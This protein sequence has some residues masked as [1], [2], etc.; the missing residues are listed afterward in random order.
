MPKEALPQNQFYLAKERPIDL[1]QAPKAHGYDINQFTLG[2]LHAN[3]VKLIYSLVENGVIDELSDQDYQTFLQIYQSPAPLSLENFNAF[4]DFI[5]NQLTIKDNQIL[6]R[7]IGDILADRGRN[8][9]FILKILQK[10][11]ANGVEVRI[12]LSNHDLEFLKGIGL[13][14]PIRKDARSSDIEFMDEIDALED[15]IEKGMFVDQD[16]IDDA[17]EQIQALYEKM[18]GGATFYEINAQGNSYIELSDLIDNE[19]LAYEEV[20]TLVREVYVPM[21]QMIDYSQDNTKTTIYT[22]AHNGIDDIFPLATSL[23]LT[24]HPQTLDNLEVIIDEINHFI[25]QILMGNDNNAFEA[26]FESDNLA[27][28]FL[29]QRQDA[30]IIDSKDVRAAYSDRLNFVCGHDKTKESQRLI[31]NTTNIFNLDNH[32]GKGALANPLRE[33]HLS[34]LAKDSI[35]PLPWLKKKKLS[36]RNYFFKEETVSSTASDIPSISDIPV[37]KKAKK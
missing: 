22:H 19:I 1:T 2:D 35:S 8:D 24:S 16:D 6:V 36:K 20:L 37:H 12:I 14:Y 30:L 28:Q 13:I 21:L 18:K 27:F 3:A 25:H 23:D 4:N 5:D 31:K 17:N 9:W 10:L 15:M 34:L 7:L 32:L 29:W 26:L 33:R 11:K